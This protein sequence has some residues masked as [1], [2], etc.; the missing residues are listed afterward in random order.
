M[1]NGG[2]GG[3]G[4]GV[5]GFRCLWVSVS[6]DGL[7]PEGNPVGPVHAPPPRLLRGITF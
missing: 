4:G 7:A 3:K 2:R 1:K 5:S 6:I